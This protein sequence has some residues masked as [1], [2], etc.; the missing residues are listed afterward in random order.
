MHPVPRPRDVVREQINA[1]ALR[2]RALGVLL[3][4]AMMIYAVVVINVVRNEQY[5]ALARMPHYRPTTFEFTPEIAILLVYLGFLLPAMMWHEENPMRRTYHLAMPVERSTHALMKTFAGWVWL[6]VAT[7]MFVAIVVIVDL[8]ARKIA[9]LPMAFSARV[10]W[11]GWLVP[12]TS[13]TIAYLLG[14]S[15][16][17]GARNPAVWIVGPPILYVATSYVVGMLGYTA[18]AQSMLTLFTGRFGAAAAIGGR[19]VQLDSV[20][21]TLGMPNGWLWATVIWG[22][23]ATILLIAVSRRRSAIT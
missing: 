8:I 23:V 3:F 10:Q 21:R 12:F 16:A 17:V 1:V 18:A 14:A 5:S 4:G 2:V 19:V 15:A 7:A 20:G 22:V 11:W 13:V 6:M 9:G